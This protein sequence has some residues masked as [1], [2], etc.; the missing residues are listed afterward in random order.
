VNNALNF[1]AGKEAK[2]SYTGTAIK[3]YPLIRYRIGFAKHQGK[4]INH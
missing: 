1:S 2:K 3:S 4:N